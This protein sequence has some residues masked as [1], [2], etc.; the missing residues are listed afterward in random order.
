MCKKPQSTQL[1]K[2]QS[3]LLFSLENFKNIP[4]TKQR[5]PPKLNRKF[6]NFTSALFY[7]NKPS[8]LNL[9]GFCS[10]LNIWEKQPSH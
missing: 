6:E 7:Q 5:I 1:T 3:V 8:Q 10:W 9:I 4:G 2:S